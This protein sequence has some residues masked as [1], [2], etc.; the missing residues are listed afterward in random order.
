VATAAVSEILANAWLAAIVESAD[1]AIVGKTLDGIVTSWNPAAE[2]L[3]GYAPEEIIG[4]HIS[5]L[6]APGRENE[7]PAILERI[8]RGQKVERYD[9]VRRRKDGGLVDVALTVSPIRDGAGQ[10]IGAS[11]IVLDI[12]ARR[13]AAAALRASEERFRNLANAVPDIV[14]IADPEGNVTFANDRWFLYSG[15]TLEQNRNWPELVLH[16]DDRERCM[17]EWT[18]AVREGCDY[19][20]EVRNRRHDGEFRWFL[21]RASPIRDAAGRITAWFGST[22]DIHD[23]KIA[24]ER[25]QML[26]AELSHRVR[27]L[28]TVIQIIAERTADRAASVDAF[29]AAFRGRLQALSSAQAALVVSNWRNASLATLVR[30]ALKPYLEDG[31]RIRLDVEDLPIGPEAAFTLT[32][33]L[34]ELA[35][36]AVKYGALSDAAGRVTL[37]ASPEAGTNGEELCLVWQEDGGPPVLP[38]ETAGFGTTMLSRAIEYQH[39]GRTELIWRENGLLC[40]LHLPLS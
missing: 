13:Q 33:A 25:Q 14:W 36:N 31:G 27:N 16:P 9:T 28:L 12:T 37:T 11:K 22:T 3:F 7:M 29:L 19:E 15:M 24:E 21:T 10:I 6:A 4:R 5:V 20:I 30:G 8:R 40:R 1:E 18:R 23:R 39:Q 35:T 17:A 32:L 34:H 38:P 2:R 26:T